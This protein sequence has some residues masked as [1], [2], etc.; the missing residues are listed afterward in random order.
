MSRAGTDAE[1]K[2]TEGYTHY[3]MRTRQGVGVGVWRSRVYKNDLITDT[4]ICH[5]FESLVPLNK[6]YNVD[7]IMAS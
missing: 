3:V 1:N 4:R 7:S 2:F 6:N 5:P